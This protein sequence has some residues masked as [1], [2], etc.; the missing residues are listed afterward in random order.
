MYSV[1]Q[2]MNTKI[3][4]HVCIF[5]QQQLQHQQEHEQQQHKFC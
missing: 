2:R 5:N 1:M 3:T 4:Q